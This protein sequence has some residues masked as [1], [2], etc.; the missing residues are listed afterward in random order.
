MP[1]N[2]YKWKF[3]EQYWERVAQQPD[4]YMQLV[5]YVK[6]TQE[7]ISN[8]DELANFRKTIG[9][10]FQKLLAEEKLALASEGPDLDAQREPVS[11]VVIHHTSSAPGYSIDYMN[12][13]HLLNI[14]APYYFQPTVPEEMEL[15]GKP[16]W[17]G[18]FKNGKQNF[19][20][21]HWLMR[22]DGSLEHLLDDNQIGWHA[23]N[24][25][26]NKRSVA[27]CLDNNYEKMCPSEQTLEALATHIRK[28][29]PEVKSENIMGHCESSPGTICPGVHFLEE[30]KPKLIEYLK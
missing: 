17:S 8:V 26:V 27:I 20:G 6:K 13:V 29:Y 3:D 25:S 21:Y 19:I 23:G 28:K 14:Y 4:W 16:I 2:R 11:S 22:M 10:F 15:R 1:K 7:S 30:W 5:P 24:W 18:H 9:H 12:A